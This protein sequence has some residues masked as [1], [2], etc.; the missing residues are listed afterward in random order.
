MTKNLKPILSIKT[1]ELKNGTFLA[2]V[3]GK[4]ETPL[5]RGT[6]AVAASH[7][8]LEYWYTLGGLGRAEEEV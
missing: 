1:E 5:A 4:V 7:A 2:W 8:I 6:S 3:E